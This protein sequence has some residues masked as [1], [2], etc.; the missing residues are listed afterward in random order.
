MQISEISVK[1]Y[2]CA[3]CGC[4]LY[5]YCL[6]QLVPAYTFSLRIT[7]AEIPAALV[8]RLHVVLLEPPKTPSSEKRFEVWA[9]PAGLPCIVDPHDPDGLILG[10]VFS[11]SVTFEETATMLKVDLGLETVCL[12]SMDL[13]GP[14]PSI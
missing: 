3:K 13:L 12:G 14:T 4:G 6:Y 9:L 7:S 1:L 8:S 5:L 11:T 10:E 2:K